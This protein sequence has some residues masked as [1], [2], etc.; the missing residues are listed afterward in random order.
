MQMNNNSALNKMGVLIKSLE[1][2]CDNDELMKQGIQSNRELETKKILLNKTIS[3]EDRLKKNE[4]AKRRQIDKINQEYKEKLKNE[5]I[6]KEK[7]EKFNESMNSSFLEFNNKMIEKNQKMKMEI[8]DNIKVE[9]E[10][11]K[12]MENENH[13]K[14]QSILIEME[15]LIKD[16]QNEQ[17][18][19]DLQRMNLEA[20]NNLKMWEMQAK[21][22]R[23]EEIRKDKIERERKLEEKKNKIKKQIKIEKE[24]IEPT[25]IVKMRTST[26]STNAGAPISVKYSYDLGDA[27]END[28]IGFHMMFGSSN[29][30]KSSLEPLHKIVC[31]QKEGEYKIN[32]PKEI[33]LYEFRFYRGE[34]TSHLFVSD[35]VS[36]G[37]SVTIDLRE[38]NNQVIANVT[39]FNDIS[40]ISTWDSV[41][42]FPQVVTS[43]KSGC[44]E[45]KYYTSNEL[46]FKKPRQPG[47]YVVKYMPFGSNWVE[48]SVSNVF[49]VEN[50]DYF[51][52]ETIVK[53]GEFLKIDWRILS[54]DMS[55]SDWIS[56]CPIN[57]DKYLDYRETCSLETEHSLNFPIKN[58]MKPGTYKLNFNSKA[59]YNNPIKTF[60]PIEVLPRDDDK[61]AT[62]DLKIFV[63]ASV[64]Y[65]FSNFPF[66]GEVPKNLLNAKS[67]DKISFIQKVDDF[68][69]IGRLNDLKG[70]Y[71]LRYVE[72]SLNFQSYF[73]YLKLLSG[74]IFI[75]VGNKDHNH[76]L[77][78]DIGIDTC[79]FFD[80]LQ[81][82][83]KKKKT[84]KFG[85]YSC[86]YTGSNIEEDSVGQIKEDSSLFYYLC[87]S[88]EDWNKDTDSIFFFCYQSSSKDPVDSCSEWYLSQ[89]LK[90]L[91]SCSNS[92]TLAHKFVKFEENPFV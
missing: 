68:L 42:I 58:S 80:Q 86:S 27:G 25:L 56:I 4:I 59:S 65:P 7:L 16:A 26:S 50:K 3:V 8:E 9:M 53:L 17:L 36:V 91:E 19:M 84:F 55:Y 5:E 90:Q 46:S 23:E 32:A 71:P 45:W 83:Y 64:L 20:K 21:K 85:E 48:T 10:K 70:F 41:G 39:P 92:F 69:C 30:Q 62:L 1:T 44:L 79:S 81:I 49:V 61:N 24:T 15:N 2:T 75:F 38:E 87:Y 29:D 12:K 28:M 51:R 73:D 22:R 82:H 11:D 6:D 63:T 40:N 88:N 34:N 37:K 60:G 54:V 33:G 13:L 43:N 74:S 31:K 47:N 78:K 14:K 35:P 72:H 57:S 52:S 76:V 18:K 67:G 66:E 89:T 77:S